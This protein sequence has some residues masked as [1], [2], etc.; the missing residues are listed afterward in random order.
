MALSQ[1]IKQMLVLVH[2]VFFFF[3]FIT[4]V[5]FGMI[6]QLCVN[7][8]SKYYPIPQLLNFIVFFNLMCLKAPGN[9]AKLLSRRGGGGGEGRVH[10]CQNSFLLIE[11]KHL[12][13]FQL[14]YLKL[15]ILGK[16]LKS[17]LNP[18]LTKT[19]KLA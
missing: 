13:H 10:F 18:I 16:N 19:M 15:L 14:L 3:L 11:N 4:L 17:S 6:V 12:F 2:V 1:Q 7:L 5:N 9:A 8:K